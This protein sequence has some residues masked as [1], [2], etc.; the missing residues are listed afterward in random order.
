MLGNVTNDLELQAF[1]GKTQ[2]MAKADYKASNGKKT[3][4]LWQ[5]KGNWSGPILSYETR[6]ILQELKKLRVFLLE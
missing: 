5:C 1:F 4:K 2:E 6:T 3:V